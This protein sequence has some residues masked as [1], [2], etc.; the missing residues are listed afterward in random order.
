M[1][2]FKQNYPVFTYLSFPHEN[3]HLHLYRL[4]Y[5][6]LK[7][8]YYYI[9]LLLSVLVVFPT[10]I[11]IRHYAVTRRTQKWEKEHFDPDR[12]VAKKKK[13]SKKSSGRKPVVSKRIG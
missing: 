6:V 13:H 9:I 10:C 12:P 2:R 11:P 3:F 1:P 4:I 7:K 8:K 5:K